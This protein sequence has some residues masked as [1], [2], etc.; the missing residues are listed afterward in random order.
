MEIYSLIIGLVVGLI[1]AFVV[2][3]MLNRKLQ[4]IRK[5]ADDLEKDCAIKDGQ[6]DSIRQLLQRERDIHAEQIQSNERQYKEQIQGLKEQYETRLQEEKQ[7]REQELQKQMSLVREQMQ[8]ATN[9]M[10]AKREQEFKES[11]QQQIGQ[12]LNPLQE[13]IKRMKEAVEKGKEANIAQATSLEKQIEM[14]MKQSESIGMHA[15]NLAKALTSENKTQGNFGEMKLTELLEGMELEQGIHFDVQQTMRDNEGR[16]V[17]TDEGSRLQPDVILH[18]TD[19]RDAIIDSKMSLKSFQDYQLATTPEEKKAALDAHVISVRKHV[20]ELSRKNYSS[21]I[22]KGRKS[23]NYVLMYMYSEAALQLAL[24]TDTGLW[25]YA[26]NKGVFITGSQNLYAVLR[27]T[28]ESWTIVEQ[29]RNQEQ[30]VKYADII[31]Q[32]VKL[33]ADRFKKVGDVI[34][35][36]QDSYRDVQTTT[37]E[38]GQSIIVAARQLT[39]LGAKE[40]KRKN[41][42]PPNNEGE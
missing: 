11:N 5:K 17:T 39:A 13:E 40:E 20:D 37:A 27:L 42:L 33:F 1:V 38:S 2:Y 24:M 34:D 22:A 6:A 8:N 31:V 25:R 9:E 19:N 3:L 26:F 7:N 41:V 32:R 36:L 28:K 14:L 10:L 21:Y 30:M 12:I 23:L 16:T 15:D 35:K 29:T 4:D 18:F